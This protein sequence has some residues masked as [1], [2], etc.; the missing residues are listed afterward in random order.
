METDDGLNRINRDTS[1]APRQELRYYDRN[2]IYVTRDDEGQAWSR[3]NQ[4]S[5]LPRASGARHR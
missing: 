2:A 5:L 3:Y 4:P 1:W